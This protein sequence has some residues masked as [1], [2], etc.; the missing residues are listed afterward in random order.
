MPKLIFK[1]FIRIYKE[2]P[3]EALRLVSDEENNVD[4]IM[5]AEEF[6]LLGT[7]RSQEISEYG[8][9][10]R[11]ENESNIRTRKIIAMHRVIVKLAERLSDKIT[12]LF[13]E[14]FV[15]FLRLS[16]ASG[17]AAIKIYDRQ[18]EK[19]YALV[20]TNQNF[21]Q[22]VNANKDIAKKFLEQ[23]QEKE[24]HRIGGLFARHEQFMELCSPI[25]NLAGVVFNSEPARI[26]GLFTTCAQFF[27]LH[28][29]KLSLARNVF[30]YD[31]IRIGSLFTTHAQFFELHNRDSILANKIFDN[32]PTR[33][34]ELFTT[35]RL[36]IDLHNKDYN[37]AH[38]VFNK[39]PIRI[40]SLFTNCEQFLNLHGLD[41][42]IARAIFNK[43][44]PRMAKIF[45]TEETL[46]QLS[47][48]DSSL[49]TEL[50]PLC[51][52]T[53]SRPNHAASQHSR[54]RTSTFFSPTPVDINEEFVTPSLH[55]ATTHD[56]N[57]SNNYFG[58]QCFAMLTV[59]SVALLLLGNLILLPDVAL[60]GAVM[61]GVGIY[62]MY[63]SLNQPQ[64]EE[65]PSAFYSL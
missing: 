12:D 46:K 63:Q 51:T 50:G 32:E 47:G 39:D 53:A 41:P 23:D 60:V 7:M 20:K 24:T 8:S 61:A 16:E 9:C 28:K 6:I 19:L 13:C 3:E 31:P 21:I 15:S 34:I 40:G 30:D 43:E 25:H 54:P 59:G 5:S 27:E 29:N 17:T 37:L 42:R 35:Y 2:N 48:I 14:D 55:K 36:F 56:E 58:L 64:A 38:K 44:L 33:I 45:N 4:F 62:G 22:L 52:L 65:S 26:S 10:V 11:T 18:P 49:A 1:E 57:R